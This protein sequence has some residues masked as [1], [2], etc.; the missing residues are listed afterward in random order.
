M[1]EPTNLDDHRPPET[2]GTEII[3]P[4]RGDYYKL[5]SHGYLIPSVVLSKLSQD[6]WSL[7]LDDRFEMT[8][9]T[10]EIY[11]WAWML[12]NAMAISAGYSCLGENCQPINLFKRRIAALKDK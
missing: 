9:P 5:S 10:K 2:Y 11:R 6:E 1:T 3:G 8:A 4:F 7:L 12:G